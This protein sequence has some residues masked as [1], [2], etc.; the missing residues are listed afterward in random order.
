MTAIAPISSGPI[1][2]AI[3]FLRK[4]G[5]VAMPTETVYGLACDAANPDAVTR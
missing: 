3:S 1:D 2:L 4:G 5:L